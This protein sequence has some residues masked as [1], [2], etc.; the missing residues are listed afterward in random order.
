MRYITTLFILLLI[1][2]S[3]ANGA[4]NK[5]SEV[6]LKNGKRLILSSKMPDEYKN[7]EEID[8]ERHDWA[9][10]QLKGN[11]KS[12]GEIAVL[13]EIA[14][15]YANVNAS[16]KVNYARVK[17]PSGAISSFNYSVEESAKITYYSCGKL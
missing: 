16:S 14:I 3:N 4:E 8:Q 9:D 13:N 7:C 5:T 6:K 12:G 17:P 2:Y 10:V 1:T 11:L 15:N